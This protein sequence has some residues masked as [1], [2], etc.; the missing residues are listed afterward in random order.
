MRLNNRLTRS[1]ARA[2]Q[3]S[4]RANG[5][6]EPEQRHAGQQNARHF[7]GGPLREP[8]GRG[9]L[10]N[11]YKPHDYW[12][13]SVDCSFCE[14]NSTVRAEGRILCSSVGQNRTY[15]CAQE[16]ADSIAVR[17][18]YGRATQH[19]YRKPCG[20]NQQNVLLLTKRVNTSGETCAPSSHGI[21]SFLG[22]LELFFTRSPRAR[23]ARDESCLVKY[24][25]L[26]ATQ[27]VLS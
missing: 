21:T 19:E 3:A 22:V 17:S 27:D 23:G 14:R 26:C 1:T 7:Q 25:P 2:I 16:I 18:L 13:A 24:W 11:L 15:H 12:I 9:R 5:A 20:E 10:I 8:S 6:Q 4:P